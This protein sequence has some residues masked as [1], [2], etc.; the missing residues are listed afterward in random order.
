MVYESSLNLKY[1]ESFSVDYYEA[2]YKKITDWSGTK[3]LIVPEGGQVPEV[4]KSI[5]IIQ[6]PIDRVGAFST[7]I[8][9]E[10]KALGLLDKIK[11]LTTAEENGR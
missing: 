3:T 9:I 10:M 11:L 6:Q 7:P 2:G 4:D 1:A 8:A 5:N